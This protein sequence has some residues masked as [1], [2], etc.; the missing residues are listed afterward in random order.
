MVVAA[1]AVV[2]AAV[3]AEA[4]KVEMVEAKAV[5]VVQAGLLEVET[6]SSLKATH[7]WMWLI[8][9]ETAST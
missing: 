4:A 1:V 2:V 3:A 8:P 9:S 7:F 6:L 5:V